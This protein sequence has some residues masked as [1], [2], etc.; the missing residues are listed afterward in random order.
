MPTFKQI[1]FKKSYRISFK[2]PE[3]FKRLLAVLCLVVLQRKVTFCWSWC[4]S[5]LLAEK[6]V[7]WTT[8]LP[9]DDGIMTNDLQFSFIS[10]VVSVRSFL[11]Q[12]YI[13]IFVEVLY[14][15]TNDMDD[16]LTNK[17]DTIIQWNVKMMIIE[18]L[19]VTNLKIFSSA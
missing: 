10:L 5:D 15:L 12:K 13:L 17:P 2:V 14:Y 7:L 19:I 11:V 9:Q 3:L 8:V 16:Q 6:S 1:Q 4:K 18:S